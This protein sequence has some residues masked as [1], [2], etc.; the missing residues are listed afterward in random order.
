M[1][2]NFGC[3]NCYHNTCGTCP[4]PQRPEEA[5]CMDYA[6][7]GEAW[8]VF[9]EQLCPSCSRHQGGLCQL[10]GCEPAYTPS[11]SCP[12]YLAGRSGA[13]QEETAPSEPGVPAL[14][15]EPAPPAPPLTPEPLAPT[16]TPMPNP[17]SPPDDEEEEEEEDE[18][19][20]L[21]GLHDPAEDEP[22]DED[23]DDSFEDDLYDDD[24][25]YDEIEDEENEEDPYVP[26]EERV[27]FRPEDYDR[28]GDSSYA[29]SRLSETPPPRRS[30]TPVRQTST[31]SRQSTPRTQ[32]TSSSRP[33]TSVPRTQ[34]PASPS[35]Q[36]TP[37]RST[38]SGG[39]VPSST[40]QS[41]PQ[42]TARPQPPTPRRK[43]R[44][45]HLYF[46]N[47]FSL[48]GVAINLVAFG[49]IFNMER[50]WGASWEVQLGLLGAMLGVSFLWGLIWGVM[51]PQC[52]PLRFALA[53]CLG[54]SAWMLDE[55]TGFSEGLKALIVGFVLMC[56]CFFLAW[57]GT[58]VTNWIFRV[59]KRL[60]DSL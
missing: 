21:F 32:T 10:T 55:K 50:W 37:S 34:Q 47:P 29:S 49:A 6:P 58:A 54:V 16:P 41:S 48:I 39:A 46:L 12:E 8:Q 23:E 2:M 51:N 17:P 5:F 4:L 11:I 33:N 30:N 35:R 25:E 19:E 43:R 45:L 40:R 28:E 7:E 56:A 42:N 22:E 27:V 52:R 20:I 31:A 15:P 14:T 53:A 57:L 18:D 36:S 59:N 9:R 1:S 24:S 38:P 13:Q 44:N 26:P 3:S 60:R